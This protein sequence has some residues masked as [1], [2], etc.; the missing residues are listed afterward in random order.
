[1]AHTKGS[2]FGSQ[3]SATL[4]IPAAKHLTYRRLTARLYDAVLLALQDG[5]NSFAP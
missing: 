3:S 2:G 5:A 4:N 1:M